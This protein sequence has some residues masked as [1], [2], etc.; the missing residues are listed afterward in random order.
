[1]LEE[2]ELVIGNGGLEAAESLLVGRFLMFSTVYL[3]KTVRIGSA[4]LNRGI[5]RSMEDGM[6]AEEFLS[7]DELVLEKMLATERGGK[8]ARALLA[9]KLYKQAFS[10]EGALVDAEEAEQDLSSECGCE[11]I[12]DLPPV[13]SRPLDIK[14]KT[15]G[16]LK[17]IME[18]SDLVRSLFLAE[19]N[20]KK[21]LIL[22]PGAE[23]E[24]VNRAASDYFK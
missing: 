6:N 3:H 15:E 9:R 13:L 1:M 14:V 18:I 17:A 22:C 23:K 24:K 7:T 2:D 19:E 4:M 20:R 5:L 8:Y 16:G 10:V 21:T 11:V 12:V